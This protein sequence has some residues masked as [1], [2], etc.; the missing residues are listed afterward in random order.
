[1]LAVFVLLIYLMLPMVC[2]DVCVVVAVPVVVVGCA[3]DTIGCGSCVYVVGVF[4]WL[5]VSDIAIIYVVI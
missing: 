5:T 1:M 3:G 4:V 2:C